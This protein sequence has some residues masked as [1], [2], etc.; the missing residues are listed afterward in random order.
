MKIFLQG[1]D[2]TS[3]FKLL[4]MLLML[5][6]TVLKSQV[7]LVTPTFYHTSHNLLFPVV[8]YLHNILNRRSC[9]RPSS[10]LLNAVNVIFQVT[11]V[12]ISEGKVEFNWT[13]K[14]NNGKLQKIEEKH[15]NI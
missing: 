9:I 2:V 7:Q 3:V 6:G 14:L 1:V 5:W 13:G 8:I 12:R 10:Q 4:M 15:A 11:F